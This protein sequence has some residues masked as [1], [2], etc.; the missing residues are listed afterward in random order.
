MSA[1][2]IRAALQVGNV[3]DAP[4]FYSGRGAKEGDLPG[5]TLDAVYEAIHANVG[6]EAAGKFVQMVADIPVLSAT[7]FLLSLQSFELNKWTWAER[8]TPETR[9]IYADSIGSA[10]GTFL[11]SLSRQPKKDDTARIRGRFLQAHISELR[12]NQKE[13][14]QTEGANPYDD[15]FFPWRHP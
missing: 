1:E 10:V 14:A 15:H 5:R 13:L 11:E 4:S 2:F 3:V 7:D 9:G 6:P 8:M 12:E